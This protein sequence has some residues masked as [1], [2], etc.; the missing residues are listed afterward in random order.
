MDIACLENTSLLIGKTDRI[1]YS[2]GFSPTI[3]SDPDLVIQVSCGRDH[4][5]VLKE[6]GLVDAW[7]N[8]YSLTE[9]T[10]HRP[11]AGLRGIKYI[12]AGEKHGLAV[13]SIHNSVIAWGSNEYGQSNV[14]ESIAGIEYLNEPVAKVGA[15]YSYSLAL[16]ESGTILAWGDIV[17]QPPSSLS[18][19]TVVDISTKGKHSLAL[20][21]DGTVIGWGQITNLDASSVIHTDAGSIIPVGLNNVT[22][23]SAGFSHCLALKSDGTVVAWGDNTYGQCN[24][25]SGLNNVYSICAGYKHSL[26]IKN[27]GSIVGWGDNTYNQCSWS[28]LSHVQSG[29]IQPKVE[30]YG[31][32]SYVLTRGGDLYF[33]GTSGSINSTSTLVDSNV[34]DFRV[35]D[36]SD[37]TFS[38]NV[39]TP[40]SVGL[41]LNSNNSS[42]LDNFFIGSLGNGYAV[43]Y[44]I[45]LWFYPIGNQNGKTLLADTFANNQC[46]FALAWFNNEGTGAGSGFKFGFYGRKRIYVG[47]TLNYYT[48][49]QWYTQSAGAPWLNTWN[50]VLIS[51]ETEQI[52]SG[53]TIGGKTNLGGYKYN[54]RAYLNGVHQ[55]SEEHYV[56][57]P[58]CGAG[59]TISA[60]TYSAEGGIP[61]SN[62]IKIG[63]RWDNNSTQ[64]KF[65][66]YVRNC[67]IKHGEKKLKNETFTPT[68]VNTVLTPIQNDLSMQFTSNNA[69]ELYSYFSQGSYFY[70]FT[71]VGDGC[72]VYKKID[73]TTNWHGS[74]T[75]NRRP[76]FESV[77]NRMPMLQYGF[78]IDSTG[79]LKQ[80]SGDLALHGGNFYYL[81]N[82]LNSPVEDVISISSSSRIHS[83]YDGNTNC[84][85]IILTKFGIVSFAPF[86]QYSTVSNKV[87]VAKWM[88]DLRTVSDWLYDSSPN[89]TPFYYNPQLRSLELNTSTNPPSPNRLYANQNISVKVVNTGVGDSSNDSYTVINDKD[90]IP[91][92]NSYFCYCKGLPN[93]LYVSQSDCQIR[94]NT[95]EAA[96]FDIYI[97]LNNF[98]IDP[99]LRLLRPARLRINKYSYFFHQLG[100]ANVFIPDTLN[101][102]VDENQFLL[103]ISGLPK[104]NAVLDNGVNLKLNVDYNGKKNLP[105][106]PGEYIVTI[107]TYDF[108]VH[109]IRSFCIYVGEPG[110]A[111]NGNKEITGQNIVPSNN[112][113]NAF[114]KYCRLKDKVSE[115]SSGDTSFFHDDEIL[116]IDEEIPLKI[117]QQS[118]IFRKPILFKNNCIYVSS[119]YQEY[120]Y[121][122]VNGLTSTICADNVTGTYKYGS[123]N[124]PQRSRMVFFDPS[125]EIKYRDFRI[126]YKQTYLYPSAPSFNSLF[127]W[128]STLDPRTDQSTYSLTE[129]NGSIG[130]INSQPRYFANDI[131]L[132]NVETKIPF[133]T[134]FQAP[135]FTDKSGTASSCI[136]REIYRNGSKIEI[137]DGPTPNPDGSYGWAII[138]DY[139]YISRY[140]GLIFSDDV[141]NTGETTDSIIS[142]IS[143]SVGNETIDYSKP[144]KPIL[145]SNSNVES[146]S[147][148]AMWKRSAEMTSALMDISTDLNFSNILRQDVVC[149]GSTQYSFPDSG[150]N[151]YFDLNN[152]GITDVS[153][154]IREN[155][156]YYYRIK[157]KKNEIVGDYSATQLVSTLFEKI[158]VNIV[159]YFIG[160]Q[161][162]NIPVPGESNSGFPF[163]SIYKNSGQ[164][165]LYKI[166]FA[167]DGQTYV[168]NIDRTGNNSSDAITIKIYIK[169][170]QYFLFSYVINRYGQLIDSPQGF[171]SESTSILASNKNITVKEY[172]F[173]PDIRD[174]NLEI[175]AYPINSLTD[176]VYVDTFSGVNFLG[177]NSVLPFFIANKEVT[178]NEWEQVR[179]YAEER[180]WGYDLP[181]ASNYSSVHEPMSNI[182]WFDAIKFCNAKSE[183]NWLSPVY[184]NLD[185]TVYKN[186]QSVLPQIK[187]SN[188][189]Y[190]LPLEIEWDY[191]ARGGAF[192]GSYLYSGSNLPNSVSVN[193][194]NSGNAKNEVA[195]LAPNEIAVYDMSGNISEW[196]LDNYSPADPVPTSQQNPD[197]LSTVLLL[198]FN[199]ES[200]PLTLGLYEPINSDGGQS[201]FLATAYTFPSYIGFKLGPGVR[202]RNC[203]IL[204]NGPNIEKTFGLNHGW[205][206]I[207]Y[208]TFTHNINTTAEGIGTEGG[209][210]GFPWSN[211]VCGFYLDISPSEIA[212]STSITIDYEY[213]SSWASKQGIAFWNNVSTPTGF[214]GDISSDWIG[215]WDNQTY[216][217][218]SSNIN[219]N[220][221]INQ[222]SRDGSIHR[223][224]TIIQK[225]AGQYH[226][227]TESSA[228]SF[229][230]INDSSLLGLSPLNYSNS[231]PSS[232]VI[233]NTDSKF[234]GYSLL[235][236]NS[237]NLGV[238]FE[239]NNFYDF[240]DGF[241][242][243]FWFKFLGYDTSVDS[244]YNTNSHL[245]R[246]SSSYYKFGEWS[247]YLS[248]ESNNVYLNVSGPDNFILNDKN[249]LIQ[250][251]QWNHFAWSYDPKT[252]NHIIFLNGIIYKTG[253]KPIY[254]TDST[255][256][257][258]FRI[259]SR[260]NWSYHVFNGYV[261]ELYFTSKIRYTQDFNLPTSPYN[262]SKPDSL[263]LDISK[264]SLIRGGNYTSS[265]DDL[266]INNR[267]NLYSSR[268]TR[269]N[270][271]GLRLVKSNWNPV[272]G[273]IGRLFINQ[274]TQ[275]DKNAAVVYLNGASNESLSSNDLLQVSVDNGITWTNTSTN[276][277]FSGWEINNNQYETTSTYE[278][279]YGLL[280]TIQHNKTNF[281]LLRALKFSHT[282]NQTSNVIVF[283]NFVQA[284]DI[285][286]IIAL[287]Y[288]TTIIRINYSYTESSNTLKYQYS[289]N[290]TSDFVDVS[291]VNTF[292]S[293]LVVQDT[294]IDRTLFIKIRAIDQ[295][296]IPSFSS[297]SKLIEFN[298]YQPV[299][300]AASLSADI[301]KP[302]T[303][304]LPL[305]VLYTIDFGPLEPSSFQYYFGE[306]DNTSSWSDVASSSVLISS[307]VA[308]INLSVLDAQTIP[309]NIVSRYG[310]IWGNYSEP[311]SSIVSSN[312]Q[313]PN[314]TTPTITSADWSGFNEVSGVLSVFF[315]Y[316]GNFYPNYSRTTF[317]YNINNSSE[318]L[319]GG[320]SIQ[321]LDTGNNKY[322]LTIAQFPFF[323]TNPVSI[324]IKI[325]LIYSNTEKRISQESNMLEFDTIPQI[326][327]NPVILEVIS[328]SVVEEYTYPGYNMVVRP[329]IP[330][331]VKFSFAQNTDYYYNYRYLIE[332]PGQSA[333]WEYAYYVYP[334]YSGAN[335]KLTSIPLP[336]S[337]EERTLKIRASF[338]SDQYVELTSDPFNLPILTSLPAYENRPLLSLVSQIGYSDYNWEEDTSS[339]TMSVMVVPQTQV[340][341]IIGYEFNYR[342]SQSGTVK[343]KINIG[344]GTLNYGELTFPDIYITGL[345]A[346]SLDITVNAVY[347]DGTRSQES[348]TIGFY[349]W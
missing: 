5:L 306:Q 304:N 250:L 324:K 292:S 101:N 264:D 341:D 266:E 18:T 110:I 242:V 32:T 247:V 347:S 40:P 262:S 154:A 174:L 218:L 81:N 222:S 133:I 214:N 11:P 108:N 113:A 67:Q 121:L 171:L 155:T 109:C 21:D 181:A 259:C 300:L 302:I 219:R 297:N 23:I 187:W 317:L 140:I 294:Q 314:P 267:T 275:I 234:D 103:S 291:N 172:T 22:K 92:L 338:Y 279:T 70:D 160:S 178:V 80:A 339:V 269:D 315:D 53:G 30:A 273:Q 216:A 289:I 284:P 169:G 58:S 49:Y 280:I 274:I 162:Q 25:P 26:V 257:K 261:D 299:I 268:S 186:G 199:D 45:E 243:D 227:I 301:N 138:E 9:N 28:Q 333:Y 286:S 8:I 132:Y 220:T 201:R 334:D 263:V 147:F 119:G 157:H 265:S 179:L 149:T 188:S 225:T 325:Q 246:F 346:W 47:C 228:I 196:V 56:L 59:S 319:N 29:A 190:R 104:N 36:S 308:S 245:I 129:S 122:D 116:S 39:Y 232:P 335:N 238:N 111:L 345:S 85:L 344:A 249:K 173:S 200:P 27:D 91:P 95:Y 94:G 134:P 42:N 176:F 288:K 20:I 229:P 68:P 164:T 123:D 37:V 224:R 185:D 97:N 14:P 98:L 191:A 293:Y 100:Y 158:K 165:Y 159:N 305:A 61:L 163:S 231:S 10:M 326:S 210:P 320:A 254:V 60:Y 208:F 16:M 77:P 328:S 251:N 63:R 240:C 115:I 316:D 76:S 283:D 194:S 230:T 48:S 66:G 79:K 255:V 135:H 106:I 54:T 43:S 193:S 136:Y 87:S 6:D 51:L 329:S 343:N 331:T 204:L 78:E 125:V 93:L 330:T 349:L 213:T 195:T 57:V 282:Q 205:D 31:Q 207:K 183:M 170:A 202:I 327:Q 272:N 151:R 295:N 150:S 99:S 166:D 142:D 221:I 72:A 332:S 7:G 64:Y 33:C 90:Y 35:F 290:N 241:T 168:N 281:I 15:G 277:L 235:S 244:W 13:E 34:Q 139:I 2:F 17:G 348:N 148:R 296:N 342:P 211:D 89:N 167:S 117:I 318:W 287:S 131:N 4:S 252:F 50:H 141:Y 312:I 271:F 38:S 105:K 74:G 102:V 175:R 223:R 340:S 182:S 192:S 307:N 126:S 12:S 73:G 239:N 144:F 161:E 137:K 124:F 198:H 310:T 215:T 233:M 303:N 71:P 337:T 237:R 3:C 44:T 152:N 278:A 24:V 19:K 127:F 311:S 270:K 256:T 84:H 88:R 114:L 75:D 236:S 69:G 130:I 143:L 86:S 323:A 52:A 321:K 253:I 107:T 313:L 258:Y 260:P 189:G 285:S 65:N 184:L 112:R 55:S 96:N 1:L 226:F 82:L 217:R 118:L 203:K 177:F 248:E 145:L 128:S 146:N 322:K 276:N 298:L 120:Y 180:D 212:S 62:S 153:K 197:Y 156:N 336:I 46:S 41:Y 209:S 309:T 83:F 206:L